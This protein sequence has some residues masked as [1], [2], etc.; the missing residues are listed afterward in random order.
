M[1]VNKFVIT[2]IKLTLLCFLLFSCSSKNKIQT[3]LIGKEFT[4]KSENRE[5]TLKI[6]DANNLEIINT[7]YC[8]NIEERYKTTVFKKQYYLSNNYI[9]LRDSVFEFNLPYFNNS[10]C[11]FLSEAYRTDKNRYGF[12]GRLIKVNYE[13][14]YSLWNI[15]RLQ[16]VGKKLIFVKN[17]QGGSRGYLFE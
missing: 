13:E 7:F 16:I 11:K 5:L 2:T 10:D 3:N 15:D 12:D 17:Y 4:A 1:R 6:I 8:S 14:L 9:I